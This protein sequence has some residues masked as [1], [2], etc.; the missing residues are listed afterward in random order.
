MS[1]K[2]YQDHWQLVG[3]DVTDACLGFLNN[4][5]HLPD[6]LNMTDVTLIPKVEKPQKMTDLCPISLCNVL[7]KIISKALAN[8]MKY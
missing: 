4:A 8:R 7:Y 5:I 6:E 3:K 1:P 2:F